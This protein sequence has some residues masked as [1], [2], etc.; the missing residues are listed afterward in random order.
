[1]NGTAFNWQ[2]IIEK[3]KILPEKSDIMIMDYRITIMDDIIAT[4]EILNI[5]N[6]SRIIS[7]TAGEDIK[8]K[9]LEIGRFSFVC[10]PFNF[11]EMFVLKKN[12]LKDK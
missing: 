8:E 4:F 2:I 6:R 5:T 9:A 7:A 1:V 12:S 10:K 11:K 3:L